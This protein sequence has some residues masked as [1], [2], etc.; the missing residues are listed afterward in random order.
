MR[1]IF[2]GTPDF[3]VPTLQTLLDSEHEVVA[4]YT[5]PDKPK[6]RGNKITFPPVKELALKHDIPVYQPR[7]IKTEEAVKIY[8]EIEAD[9]V[10]VIAYGQ[11]L[12]AEIL[13]D[14]KYG[15][16][17]IHASLLPKYRGA[18]P[19][20]W[21][22][23]NGEKETGI[24]TMQMDEGMDTG[25]M[26]LTTKVEI[27]EKETAGGLHDKL[28][29]LGGDLLIETLQKIEKGEILAKQQKEEEVSYAPLLKK[30]DGLIDWSKKA[31]DI[32]RLIRGLY[33][34]PSAFTYLQGKMCKI[35]EASVVA[36]NSEHEPG[37]VIE[38]DK[39]GFIVQT[40]E[41]AL[42]VEKLQLQGKKAMDAGAFLRGNPI[43]I[44]SLLG[45]K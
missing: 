26:L 4:V 7:R 43:E 9:I 19:Y 20:Q 28:S 18:A 10:V 16:I 29:L 12:S 37:T 2:M 27:E 38:I 24:T 15:C 39:S 31:I 34:W 22:I 33:P 14:K 11:I 30:T 23:I 17:N 13:H 44:G 25:D 32:E 8:K 36:R 41:G 42:H 5:Q 1:V 3:S 6:G 45:G 35:N 21:C 40:K